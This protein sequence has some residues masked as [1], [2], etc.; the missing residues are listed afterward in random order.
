MAEAEPDRAF[1]RGLSPPQREAFDAASGLLEQRGDGLGWHHD[2]GTRLALLAGGGRGSGRAAALARALCL[3]RVGVYQHVQ[4]VRRYPSRGEAEALG[5]SGLRW[6][7]AVALLA[8]RGDAE[9]SRLEREAV[10]QNWSVDR[11]RLEARKLR[12]P[13][14]RKS[15]RGSPASRAEIGPELGRLDDATAAWL[16]A[17]RELRAAGA[18]AWSRLRPAGGEEGGSLRQRLEALERSLDQLT[19][20]AVTLRRD[21]RALLSDRPAG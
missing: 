20:D 1:L 6:A 18:D 10:R 9:R 3:S 12:P 15:R 11:L 21:L 4:F 7:M 13:G 17:H 2:L 14:V 5:R 16:A 19:G 8:V